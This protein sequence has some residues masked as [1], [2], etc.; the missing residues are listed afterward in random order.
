[1]EVANEIILRI[2][3]MSRYWELKSVFRAIDF[4]YAVIK[5]EPLSIQAYGKPGQRTSGDVD[6]LVARNDLPKLEKILSN[7]DFVT[8]VPNRADRILMMLGSHQTTM[9][10]K[11]ISSIGLLEV[12]VNFDIFWGEYR[13]KRTDIACFISDAIEMEIYGT[14]VKALP[15]I[16]AMIQLVLHHYKEMNSIYHLATHNCINLNMFKDVYYLWRNNY[17]EILPEKLLYECEK[18]EIIPYAYYVL[19]Y[20]NCLYL[21][22]EFDRMVKLFETD[23]GQAILELY[24]LAADEKRHWRVDFKTRLEVDDKLSLIKD[25]LTEHD[26]EKLEINKRIFG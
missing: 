23:E 13:G 7:N 15:P 4:D 20:T 12:D 26:R 5:G 14:K 22:D 11:P 18:L 10:T 17:N 25:D 19:Y 9:W 8:N 21:D 1:M 3:S 6:I 24:G 2:I 16:K